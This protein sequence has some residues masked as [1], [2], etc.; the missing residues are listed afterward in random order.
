MPLLPNDDELSIDYLWSPV[1]E[2]RMLHNEPLHLLLLVFLSKKVP[3]DEISRLT[4]AD[5]NEPVL[6]HHDGDDRLEKEEVNDDDTREKGA[7]QLPPNGHHHHA[8]PTSASPSSSFD[9][10][11]DNRRHCNWISFLAVQGTF[12]S[13]INVI[14]RKSQVN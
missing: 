9:T 2:G 8:T 6:V 10:L 7:S 13:K 14:C 3:M 1:R 4:D 5:T 12:D 11:I